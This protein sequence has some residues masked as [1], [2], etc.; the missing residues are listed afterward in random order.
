MSG[1]ESAA[2][3]AR[4]YLGE[5]RL[6]VEFA[7]GREIRASCRGGRAVYALGLDSE[8]GWWCSCPARGIG[9]AH[10]RALEL[11]TVR[12]GDWHGEQT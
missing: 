8:R 4:R 2:A 3:K 7:V 9:C 1:R 5:G 10:L 12:A 11:V 6:T